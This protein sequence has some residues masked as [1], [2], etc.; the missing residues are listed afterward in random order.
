MESPTAKSSPGQPLGRSRDLSTR[1]LAAADLPGPNASFRWK[2]VETTS[3]QPDDLASC[4]SY[5]LTSI[6]AQEVRFREFAPATSVKGERDAYAAT[7]VGQFPDRMTARRA[8]AVLTS[9]H[10]R[11]E[12]R[13]AEA[14]RKGDVAALETVTETGGRAAW[15]LTTLPLKKSDSAVLEA[16]GFVKVR[17]RITVVVMRHEGQDYDYA[18]GEEP[19][20]EA[21]RRAGALLRD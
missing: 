21:L 20:V 4:L 2:E 14:G 11:C 7:V 12:E 17:N 10:D 6:G 8:R 5:P 18:T 19:M 3:A 15:F 1:L 13:L 9:M 16:T